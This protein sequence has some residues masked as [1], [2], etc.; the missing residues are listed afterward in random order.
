MHIHHA[1]TG[2]NDL[3]NGCKSGILRVLDPQLPVLKPCLGCRSN[4]DD[5][6]VTRKLCN[7]LCQLLR[8][9]YGIKLRELLLSL[10]NP[11]LDPVFASS[12]CYEAGCRL[13]DCDFPC[14]SELVY[15][16]ILNQQIK[17]LRWVF[18]T[19]ALDPRNL[20]PSLSRSLL[21]WPKICISYTSS[22]PVVEMEL[23]EHLTCLPCP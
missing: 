16:F 20:L 1:T 22:R 3:L 15:G 8:I 19:P 6:H 5:R 18:S 14:R 23:H 9:I 21:G 12:V 11:R 17:I 4:L 2:N 7:S 10:W 13:M